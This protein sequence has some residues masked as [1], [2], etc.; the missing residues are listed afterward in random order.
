MYFRNGQQWLL[1]TCSDAA[2]SG[3]EIGSPVPFFLSG[4]RA[5]VTLLSGPCFSLCEPF[6]F[7]LQ[8]SVTIYVAAYLKQLLLKFFCSYFSYS[9]LP[10]CIVCVSIGSDCWSN[11][12]LKS[13]MYLY[14][15]HYQWY[16]WVGKSRPGW[17][18]AG[19]ALTHWQM[20]KPDCWEKVFFPNVGNWA[21]NLSSQQRLS[22]S[23]G[24]FCYKGTSCASPSNRGKLWTP[25][26]ELS[27]YK[28]NLCIGVLLV[29]LWNSANTIFL[30]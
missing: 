26:G 30:F 1:Y 23:N 19:K 4:S 27:K 11:L 10:Y 8:W 28:Y 22:W 3:S 15:R 5:G 7:R 13:G 25:G 24:V 14:D 17:R 21:E 16:S 9:F 2:T 20:D 18:K 12:N 29:W 6:S